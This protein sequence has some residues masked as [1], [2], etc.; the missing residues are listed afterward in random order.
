MKKSIFLLGSI[1][2]STNAYA[3]DRRMVDCRLATAKTTECKPYPSK[4]MFT[5]KLIYGKD[6]HKL[7][8]SKT[9]PPEARHK[10]LKVINV[11]DMI[12]KHLVVLDPIRF[13]GSQPSPL[14]KTAEEIR[15][16]EAFR[17]EMLEVLAAY[18]LEKEK[19][20]LRKK[21]E[22]EVKEEEIRVAQEQKFNEEKAKQLEEDKREKEAFRKEMLGVLATYKLEKEKFR[23]RKKEE[24]KQ[25]TLAKKN[26]FEKRAKRY[27]TYAVQSGDSL[28]L[29]AREFDLSAKAVLLAN[30]DLTRDS[31]LKIGQKIFIPT[32]QKKVDFIV[33]KRE[34]E[35]LKK[36][37]QS[38]LA[39]K[40]EKKYLYLNKKT[41]RKVSNEYDKKLFKTLKGKRKLRVQAT[42]YTSHG[43][44]TDSTPFLAAWNNRIRPGM[45]IIAVSRDLITKYGLGNGKKVRIQ[46]LPGYYTVRDKMN[47]RYTKRI[48]IY[49]GMNRRKAL[50]WGRKRTVIY[51]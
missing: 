4:F 44:Q 33:R 9:L 5:E 28:I 24:E 6:S 43:N 39:K 12:E 50:R 47:K 30:D 17:K 1:I 46:G 40:L 7:I 36:A 32:L 22:Q 15:E 29:I 42:A 49:M 45:K 38:K 27:A 21:Q 26:A 35:N 18:K 23:L 25:K 34:K 19:W 37:K 51:W 8:I 20:E 14:R 11:E 13:S 48:D 16:K 10:I 3:G 2:I 31:I 41:R